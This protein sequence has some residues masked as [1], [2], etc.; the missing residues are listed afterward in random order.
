MCLYQVFLHFGVDV[1]GDIDEEVEKLLLTETDLSTKR[2]AFLLLHQSNPQKAME[3]IQNQMANQ[4]L[5]EMGDILQLA[6]LEV[7]R[8]KCKQDPAQKPKLL[9]MIM[10]FSKKASESVML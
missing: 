7:F 9:R 6:I 10:D 4:N 1:I 8:R 5:E 3:Y 2:N